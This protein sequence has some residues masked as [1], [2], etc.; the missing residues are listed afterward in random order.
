MYRIEEVN[1]HLVFPTFYHRTGSA[2]SPVQAFGLDP[3]ERVRPR[4]VRALVILVHR[5]P[6]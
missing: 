6:I 4:S 1:L 5:L 3:T 2:E